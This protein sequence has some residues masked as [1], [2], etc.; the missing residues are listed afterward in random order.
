MVDYSELPERTDVVARDCIR[1]QGIS[2][3]GFHGVHD[4][5]RQNGQ[6]FSIDVAIFLDTRAAALS[7]D[8][9]KTVDYSVLATQLQALL[10]GE[11]LFLIE[12][13]AER[14][15]FIVLS[16]PLVEAVDI[17]VH[18]PEA[19]LGV[20]FRDVNVTIRRDRAD[21]EAYRGQGLSITD[22]SFESEEFAEGEVPESAAVSQGV[23]DALV[24]GHV[25]NPLDVR[26]AQARE[27]VLALGSN[28]GD[29]VGTLRVAVAKLRG[30]PE[31]QDVRVSP[32]A[33]TQAVLAEGQVPQPD[34]YNAVIVARSV[35]S[36][37]EVLAVAQRL[38]DTH[39]RL[40]D[41]HWGAR[42]LDVDV[43]SIEGLESDDPALTLPH[44]RAYMRAFV[45]R[46]WAALDPGAFLGG[47]PV[48]ELA[49]AAV[50]G[51]G[52]KRLW[53][54]WLE[55]GTVTRAQEVV[56]AEDIGAGGLETGGAGVLEGRA[57][58]GGA[59][60]EVRGLEMLALPSWEDAIEGRSPRIVDDSGVDILRG[61]D[62]VTG[63]NAGTGEGAG[64]PSEKNMTEQARRSGLL[65]RWPSLR[66]EQ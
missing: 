28:L 39:G 20:A 24:D 1:L 51:P 14:A 13:L 48:E 41:E 36:A 54:E 17:T 21:Y 2:A 59:P 16:N 55:P 53:H 23:A 44:P 5:E 57:F 34:Y 31:L 35:L 61:E 10:T 43:I 65:P 4:F 22:F 46:P 25:E 40:R 3:Q 42:T 37:R 52:V 18:K 6:A 15:A 58:I 66:G 47:V 29:P 8:L 50:D 38:E 27:I 26:P 63:D 12:R 45:L 33:R 11:P 9:D 49:K 30:L 56:S 62:M 7:D 60:V 19:P 64:S 32:L